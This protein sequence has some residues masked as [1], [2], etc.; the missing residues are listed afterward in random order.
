MRVAAGT[1]S[2]KHEAT[3]SQQVRREQGKV[4]EEGGSKKKKALILFEDIDLVFDDLDDGFYGAVTTLVQQTK[5]PIVLTTSDPGFKIFG[6]RALRCDPEVIICKRSGQQS[7]GAC[8]GGRVQL[9]Q[10][11]PRQDE[12][13]FQIQAL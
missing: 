5:R 2:T 8:S 11:P 6:H 1:G 12:Q 7:P 10:P 9:V 13:P 3:Q 4:K